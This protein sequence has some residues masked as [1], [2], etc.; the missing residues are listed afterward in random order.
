MNDEKRLEDLR[1]KIMESI[2]RSDKGVVTVEDKRLNSN[3][4]IVGT[5]PKRQKN[6]AKLPTAPKSRDDQYYRSGKPS[7]SVMAGTDRTF[8]D[9]QGHR[10]A[11]GKSYN[12][13]NRYNSHT[14][15]P[16]WNDNSYGRQRDERRGRNER[17][18]RRGRNGGGNYARFDDQR[19]N[20][21]P[22]F[23]GDRDKRQAPIN[24]HDMNYNAQ[25]VIYP[26]SAFDSPAYYNMASSR[27][28]S[29]LVISGLSHSGNSSIV[30]DLKKLLENFIVGLKETEKNSEDFK[31]TDFFISK[32]SPDHIIVEFGSQ[33]CST[34]VL[35][36]RSF[37]NVKLNSV[38]LDWKRPND[39]IQQ[40]DHLVGFCRGTVIALED[41]EYVSDGKD[42]RMK[43][44]IES[45]NVQNGAAKPLFYNSTS[46]ANGADKGSEFTKCVL[47]L[48]EVVSQGILDKLKPYKW[49]KPND[50][51]TSQVTSWITFQS[52]PNLVT[53]SV[54]AESRVLLLLNCLDPLDLKDDAFI[55]EIKESLRYSIKDI[56]IIKICQPG[57]DYRL[58]FENLA[59]G[60][61]NIYIKFNTLEAAR[62]AMEEL[63]GTQFN[64]RTVLCTYIDENDFEIIEEAQLS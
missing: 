49:F 45:F 44:L 25:N 23:N 34:M 37:F 56:D 60:A 21:S 18:D 22:K 50:G 17:L 52:L 42:D 33:L 20:E 54:R 29:R 40:L 46:G 47:L 6:D 30:A 15:R 57:V 7:S 5:H 12:R 38:G 61:G 36:C 9:N 24:R 26:G 14:I 8:H 64:D 1:S 41:L 32:G 4:T 28:N 3:N 51:T 11:S 58:N 35:A 2:N 59:T 63:P 48:F 16:Q 43:E 62:Y 27:A 19:R 55:T 53:Q 10:D 39:Y 31:I 13:E